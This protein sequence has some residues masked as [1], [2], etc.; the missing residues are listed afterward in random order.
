MNEQDVQV[1]SQRRIDEVKG[2][3]NAGSNELVMDAAILLGRE[4]VC[5]DG[6]EIVGT[7]N[8]L[9]GEHGNPNLKKPGL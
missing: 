4:D 6:E 5:A 1:R 7:V 8:K 3:S 2:F 9:E